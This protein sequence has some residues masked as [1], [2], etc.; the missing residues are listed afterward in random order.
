MYEYYNAYF[1]KDFKDNYLKSLDMIRDYVSKNTDTF[2][3]ATYDLVLDDLGKKREDSNYL[4]DKII[5]FLPNGIEILLPMEEFWNDIKDYIPKNITKLELP[6]DFIEKD[7]MFLSNFTNLETLVISDYGRLFPEE[8]KVIVENTSVKNIYYKGSSLGIE[9]YANN[10]GFSVLGNPYGYC[11][12]GNTLYRDIDEPDID[13][14]LEGYFRPSVEIKSYDL[15]ASSI[16]KL[17]ALADDR[18][19][20]D[21][22]IETMNCKYKIKLDKEK[23]LY[24]IRV[25]S[26]NAFDVNRI[27]NYMSNKGMSI[28]SVLWKMK[29][30]NYYDKDISCLDDV[31]RKTKL[32]INY[33]EVM[34]A[35][36]EEFKSLLESVKWYR[37]IIN[38]SDLSPVEKVMF[39]FDILKTFKYNESST[40]MEDSRYSHKVIETGN[41]VCIG[42]SSLLMQI[43]NYLDKGIVISEFG[44][45]CFDKDNKFLGGHSRSLLKIDDDK[46][47]IHGIFALDATWDSDKSHIVT[48]D[49]ASDYTSLD[50]YRYFLIPAN[51]Y[52]KTFPG[53]SLPDLFDCYLG[54]K[55]YDYCVKSEYKALF[56]TEYNGNY[57]N[58]N[59]P[60]HESESVNTDDVSF[61][62]LLSSIDN[63]MADKNTSAKK[64]KTDEVLRSYL[65]VSRPSLQQFSEMLVNVRMAEGY[66]KEE[67]I[68]EVEKVIR[69]NKKVIGNMN[70]DGSSDIE[71]FREE[72]GVSK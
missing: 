47:N 18:I 13:S 20:D 26:D 3:I 2:S 54:N 35:S 30:T 46:Y 60:D 45:D 19:K 67:A 70:T 44:L 56:N 38:D 21:V 48:A 15:N 50:L 17:Y 23:N 53:D 14:K 31:S 72:K 52:I 37:K 61:N 9:K 29:D 16:E 57:L 66:S 58:N 32:S 27:V 51:D 34:A 55:F 43:L 63:R 39:A 8:I 69:I 10:K 6:S 5:S 59:L 11:L 1:G 36:Y 62:D 12:Y 65:S 64:N 25:E 24:Q 49:F 28:D 68:K 42:Y 4:N 7:A 41:I 40:D 22:T 71:F 33:G